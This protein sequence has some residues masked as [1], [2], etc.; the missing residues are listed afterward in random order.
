MRN[1]TEEYYGARAEAARRMA[2]RATDAGVRNVHLKLAAR[3]DAVARGEQP[4][5]PERDGRPGD[6]TGAD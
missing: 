3:Y 6:E 5:D 2:A 1:S 4:A